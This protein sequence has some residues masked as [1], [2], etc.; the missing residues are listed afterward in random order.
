MINKKL[1]EISLEDLTQLKDNA[2]SEGK[3]IEYKQELPGPQDKEKK[4]FL[5]DISSFANASGGDLIYGVSESKGVPQIIDGVQIEN[6]D[7]TVRKYASMVLAGIEPRIT[8]ATHVVKVSESKYAL[9]FRVSKSWNS[10]HR[11]IYQEHDKFYSRNATGK[12]PLDVGELRTVFNLSQSILEKIAKFKDERI[13]SLYNRGNTPIPFC[14]GGKIILHLIPFE[15]FSSGFKIDLSPIVSHANKLQPVYATGWSQRRNLEGVLSSSADGAEVSHSYVQLYRNGTVEA[16]EG[17]I[18]RPTK[19][20]KI[21]A[22]YTYEDELITALGEYIGLLRELGVN[23]PIAIYLTL[24]GVQGWRMSPKDGFRD[25][26]FEIDRDTLQ[27][28]ETILES[29]EMEPIDILR[30][31]FDIV[32]NACGYEKSRNFTE[33]G[34]WISR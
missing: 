22:S 32:W 9:I 19:T 11:V 24:T 30:P 28:P 34:L 29:Y 18:L 12:Y 31:M 21:I 23:A 6:I 25:N 16:V 33:D 1:E 10:P 4:E 26:G 20:S 8:F 7:E 3:S 15:A 17:L 5:A 13:Y 27:L 14:E 2:V